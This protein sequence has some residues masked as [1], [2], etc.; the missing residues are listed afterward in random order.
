[1][2][3]YKFNIEA[4]FTKNNYLEILEQE[5]ELF[6]VDGKKV[7]LKSLN[8][9]PINKSEGIIIECGMFDNL[10]SCI[11]LAKK[12][13]ANFLLR[14]NLSHISYILDKYSLGNFC[15][16][17]TDS[18]SSI[19][20]EIRIIDTLEKSD[21]EFAFLESAGSG[22]THFKF[23]KLLDI[24]LDKKI[25]NSLLI[26]NYRKYLSDKELDSRIDNTLISASI[27]M[28]IDET[29]R[30]EAELSVIQEVCD[31]LNEKYKKTKLCEYQAI[32]QM[33]ENNKHKS[34]RSLKEELVE[35]YSPK[36]DLKENL[37]LINIISKNRTE[38]IHVYKS[39]KRENVWADQL[40]F[41]I[42]YGY[43]KELKDKDNAGQ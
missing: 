24:S 19:Y 25:K 29:V 43:M 31:Y 40:L 13:Y 28:L 35:K 9:Q 32:K 27:E 21:G 34:I 23:D 5:K 10:E 37:D 6:E 3:R 18:D 38:E 20:K 14:L 7:M 36:R 15:K 16:Y 1:M 8:K 12:V 22:C 11:S 42:Q 33:V 4:H 41:D 17:C 39:D 26:N 2:S 30:N